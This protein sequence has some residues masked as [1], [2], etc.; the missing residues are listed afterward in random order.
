MTDEILKLVEWKY[1]HVRSLI[2]SNKSISVQ[3]RP[4]WWSVELNKANKTKILYI[5]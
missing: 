1:H 3:L 4:I 5:Q 2:L